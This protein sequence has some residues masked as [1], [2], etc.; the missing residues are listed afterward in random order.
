[1]TMRRK[2]KLLGDNPVLLPLSTPQIPVGMTDFCPFDIR[3]FK[4]ATQ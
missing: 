2:N 4:V 3:V 1:M